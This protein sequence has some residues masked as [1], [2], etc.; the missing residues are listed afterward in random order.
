MVLCS[1]SPPRRRPTICLN[2]PS[3]PAH[4]SSSPF[5]IHCPQ[6]SPSLASRPRLDSPRLASP[7]GLAL[8]HLASPRGLALP[9]LASPRLASLR[10]LASPCLSTDLSKEFSDKSGGVWDSTVV[11][12]ELDGD[13]DDDDAAADGSIDDRYVDNKP[14]L[15]FYSG[16]YF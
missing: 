2:E 7:R 13:D 14:S 6:L 5:C 1:E 16:F 10:R 11:A 15:L 3:V 12:A 8:P 9:H 4:S